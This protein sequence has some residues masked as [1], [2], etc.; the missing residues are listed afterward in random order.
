MSLCSFVIIYAR[1]CAFV[2]VHVHICL[3]ISLSPSL[4]CLASTNLPPLLHSQVLLQEFG[5]DIIVTE[6][7]D[8]TVTG[9]FEVTLVE[10]K[11]LIHSKAGGKGKAE[12]NSERGL[13]CEAIQTYLD[14]Q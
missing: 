2:C 1:S 4:F 5:D 10:T 14:S 12:S 9:N 7:K 8:P 11:Q 13:I 3:Y 6:Q